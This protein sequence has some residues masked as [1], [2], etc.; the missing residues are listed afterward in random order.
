[1]LLCLAGAASSVAFGALEVFEA[2]LVHEL[3][4]IIMKREAATVR[5][6]LQMITFGRKWYYCCVALRI[7]P[8]GFTGKMVS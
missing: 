7:Y 8:T 5:Q 4:H 2:S 1:M 3:N 6:A